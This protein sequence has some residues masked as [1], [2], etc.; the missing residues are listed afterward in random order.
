M[1]QLMSNIKPVLPKVIIYKDNNILTFDPVNRIYDF[2]LIS[3]DVEL[4]IDSSPSIAKF[5]VEGFHNIDL[6]YRID[7]WLGKIPNINNKIFSGV[8]DIKK[9]SYNRN[10]SIVTEYKAKSLGYK[11]TERIIDIVARQKIR[12]DGLTDNNDQSTEISN[13]VKK[14]IA[15][16]TAYPKVNDAMQVNTLYDEGIDPYVYV[17]KSGITLPIYI[18]QYRPVIDALQELAEI[19]GYIF[20]VDADGKLHFH[21]PGMNSNIIIFKDSIDSNDNPS[22]TGLIIEYELEDNIENVKN[23]I[24]G[25]GGNRPKISKEVTASNAYQ[26]LTEYKAVKIDL[27]GIER[28]LQYIAVRVAKVGDN[29]TL[30]L[31]GELR[32]DD[33][34]NRPKGA[35]IKAFRKDYQAISANVGLGNGQWVLFDVGEE[36][37]DVSTPHWLILYKKGEPNNTYAWYHDNSTNGVNARSTDGAFWIVNSNSY[38]FN[39]RLYYSQRLLTP[40][41]DSES[42]NK[43]GRRETVVSWPTV[44]EDVELIALTKSQLDI[45]KKR[46]QF[47]TLT[48]IPADT[49]L[50]LGDAIRVVDNINGLDAIFEVT[51]IS[52]LFDQG[53]SSHNYRF[54]VKGVRFI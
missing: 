10:N 44:I 52:Y 3:L 20:F 13:L 4:N 41:A 40:I 45:V 32:L 11:L 5:T 6:G 35:L 21:P 54:T 53:L 50:R 15:D 49:M 19:S 23:V 36:N 27:V 38:Q 43:Y 48:C 29:L 17:K 26:L 18:L 8:I 7:I 34:N 25:L 47:I 39:Y 30:P 16:V 42:I 14:I 9:Q 51:N 24:Y 22:M 2:N 28:E 37:L 33:G 31:E 12:E 1:Y 46:K